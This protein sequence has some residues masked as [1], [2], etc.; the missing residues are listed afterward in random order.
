[1]RRRAGSEVDHWHVQ[2][3]CPS[4]QV[5]TYIGSR[6]AMVPHRS[7]FQQISGI[8][9]LFESQPSQLYTNSTIHDGASMGSDVIAIKYRIDN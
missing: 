9:E 2:R 6:L 1:M 4:G 7:R 5:P 8:S 3:R